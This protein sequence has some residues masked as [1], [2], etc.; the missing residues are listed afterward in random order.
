M[1][2]IKLSNN[3]INKEILIKIFSKVI[4]IGWSEVIDPQN[5]DL[6]DIEKSLFKLHHLPTLSD[7]SYRVL[8]TIEQLLVI[9][10]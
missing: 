10:G 1:N 7:N 5:W 6:K 4:I 2:D 3:Y 8:S 9:I